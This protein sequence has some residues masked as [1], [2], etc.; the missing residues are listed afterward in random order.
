MRPCR[1]FAHLV[2]AASVVALTFVLSVPAIAQSQPVSRGDTLSTKARDSILAEVLADTLDIGDDSLLV[3]M[4]LRTTRQTITLRPTF[5]SYSVGT[6]QASEQ[7]SYT[8]WVARFPFATFRVDVT[9]IAYTGDTS[10]TGGRSQVGFN[11]VSPISARVDVPLRRADTLRVFA[12]TMSFPGALTTEDAQALGSIGT[13]TIDFDAQA[14]GVTARVGTRY[15]L[16]QAV[17]DN[18]VSI[19]LRGGLEYDPKPSGADV[20]SWRGTTV[21]VGAGVSRVMDEMTLG[22]SLEVTRSFADSLNGRNLF[23]GGG[24]LTLDARMLR[25]FGEDGLAFVAASAFYAKPL[26][27]ER[28]DQPTRLIP[29]GD[30][31]GVTAAAAIPVG[32][33]AVVPTVSVMRE[34]SS[35]GAVASNGVQTQLN[36]SGF[37]GSASVG[38]SIPLGRVMTVTPEVG[39]AF[40]SVSQTVTSSFPRRIGRPLTRSQGFSDPIRGGWFALEISLSR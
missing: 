29:V 13:S 37:T 15:T 14:L 6:V 20:V 8:S 23:P 22:T 40:G 9:P 39:G 32:R 4:L 25:Y 33:F 18:G 10:L 21:R 30:F 31:A 11:G 1:S 16:T 28:P 24:T 12:Q 7:S 5:R 26:G 17:G 36:A 27:I 34:S 38:L 19:T 35:A 3:P 2:N